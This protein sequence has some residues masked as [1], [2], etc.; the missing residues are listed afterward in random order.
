MELSSRHNKFLDKILTEDV[1]ASGT[2]RNEITSKIDQNIAIKED[3]IKGRVKWTYAFFILL[4]FALSNGLVYFMLYTTLIAELEFIQ[5]KLIQPK[6]RIIGTKVMLSLIGS[7]LV[8]TGA[9]FYFVSKK[10]FD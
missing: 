2:V 6:D 5:D 1:I 8:Q 3:K 7:T 9:A 4:V 10:V